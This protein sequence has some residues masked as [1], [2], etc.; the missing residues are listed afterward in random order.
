MPRNRQRAGPARRAAEEVG[1]RPARG[2]P[3]DTRTRLIAAAAQEFERHGFFATDSNR[4]ARAAG[5]APGTFYKHFSDKTAAFI[6]V[7]D[8]WV[9]NEWAGVRDAVKG[10]TMPAVVADRL[11]SHVLAQHREW[12]VFRAS[13]RAMNQDAKVR[14]AQRRARRAQLDAMADLGFSDRSANA[15]LLLEI[16]RVADGL[17]DGELAELGL[18]DDVVHQHICQRLLEHLGERRQSRTFAAGRRIEPA[19][20]NRRGT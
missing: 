4:I 16:E 15:L 19:A 3:A 8:A 11:A 14:S 20:I 10:K 5:Y 13:L 2:A 7:Y 1:R 6:A 9:A 17:A 12:P 18:G